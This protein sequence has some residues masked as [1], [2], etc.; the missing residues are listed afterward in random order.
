[1][2]S[3][4][5]LLIA[6]SLLTACPRAKPGPAR[7]QRRGVSLGLYVTSEDPAERRGW[8]SRFLDEI[9]AVGATDVSLV[10]RW[11]QDDVTA[12]EVAPKPGVTPP[13]EVVRE[14]AAQALERGLRVFLLPTLDVVRRRSGQWRGVI[15]PA[16][17]ERWWRSYGAFIGHYAQIA[18]DAGVSLFAVGSELVSM[19]RHADRWKALIADV[20]GRFRGRLT[21]SANWDHFEPV[22]FW[23]RLDVVGV[24]AYQGLSRKDDPTI[25]DLVAGWRPF[26]TKLQ[27]WAARNGHKYLFTEVGYPSRKGGAFRPWA[28]GDKAPAD[29]D[30]Q[31]RCYEA[32]RQVW[33]DDPRLQGIYLW[34]WFG[35]GGSQD[36]GYTPRGKPA[37]DVLKAWWLVGGR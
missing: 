11:S 37:E 27:A 10:V 13:D 1:M 33:Q 26:R 6:G 2:R 8:Y 5:L 21:Y 12:S 16:D 3:L 7:V 4:A 30:L 35:E 22:T 19:E 31:R 24:T 15:K 32:L 20:R 23:D 18:Q 14:V 28:Y 29:P 25:D 17:P 9:R 36:A 34:N